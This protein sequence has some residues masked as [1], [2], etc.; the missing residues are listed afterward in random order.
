MLN[1]EGY[2]DTV[3]IIRGNIGRPPMR[4]EDRIYFMK[5]KEVIAEGGKINSKTD[6]PFDFLIEATVPGQQLM[7]A[8]VGVDF[9]VIYE[10]TAHFHRNGK[11]LK[12]NEKFYVCVPGAGIDSTIGKK[13]IPQDFVISH[14]SLDSH[15]MAKVPKFRFEG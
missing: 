15:T 3:S 11:V 12:A 9:S 5:K 1:I 2:M 13:D 10:V 6:I 8:Y 4:E 14:D 7:E